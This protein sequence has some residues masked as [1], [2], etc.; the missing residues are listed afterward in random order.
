MIVAHLNSLGKANF[1]SDIFSMEVI[2]YLSNYINNN[3]PKM[4]F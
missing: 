2:E 4:N 3:K 1:E